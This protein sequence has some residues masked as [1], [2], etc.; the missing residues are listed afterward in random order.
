MSTSI[1]TPAFGSA[2]HPHRKYQRK[3]IPNHVFGSAAVAALVLGCAWN[4]YANVFGA[5]VYPSMAGG[6]FDAPVIRP[7][8][9]VAARNPQTV[10]NNVFAA[11]PDPA[12]AISAPATV[13]SIS[14]LDFSDRFGAAA[15]QGVK[16]QAETPKLA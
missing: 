2:S 1:S 16:S 8:Q 13:A 3:V 15:P 9:A 12:P 14:P 10:I 11:L 4:L 6:N 5:S 7:P